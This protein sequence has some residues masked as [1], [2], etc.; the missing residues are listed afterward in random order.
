MHPVV[1]GAARRH[2]ASIAVIALACAALGVVGVIITRHSVVAW[3]MTIAGGA[4]GSIAA[5]EFHDQ[6]PRVVIDDHGVLDR[7]LAVGTISWNDILDV[8]VK[9]VNSR[10]QLCLD[11]QNA[12]KYTSRLPQPLRR[13]VALNRQ[14]GLTD[15]SVDLTGLPTDPIAVEAAI[16][17]ELQRRRSP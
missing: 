15:L 13:I 17:D 12:A 9:R 16:R 1:I 6:R 11:L 2:W 7:A 3:L 5:W 10:P 4:A 8:H 14:L